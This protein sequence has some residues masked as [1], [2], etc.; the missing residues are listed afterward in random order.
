MGEAVNGPGHA[1]AL[2]I[3]RNGQA[4]FVAIAPGQQNEG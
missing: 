4:A 3:V 1:V 2:R